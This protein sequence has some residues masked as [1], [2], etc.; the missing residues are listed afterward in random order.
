MPLIRPPQVNKCGD[1]LF[2]VR[3][4]QRAGYQN[5]PGYQTQ[6]HQYYQPQTGYQ[7][8]YQATPG[9]GVPVGKCKVS[10]P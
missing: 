8:G 2:F 7:S 3:T 1:D 10:T 4:H 9:T 5:V 6:E